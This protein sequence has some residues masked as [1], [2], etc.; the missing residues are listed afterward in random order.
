MALSARTAISRHQRAP[1][2]RA[3]RH[4]SLSHQAV[5]GGLIG[6]LRSSTQAYLRTDVKDE[7][8]TLREQLHEDDQALLILYIDKQLPWREIAIV[9][10]EQTELPDDATLEREAA[11]L[12]KRFERAKVELK[13]LAI[14]KG[15]LER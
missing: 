8:R 9:M 3:D 12:R 1:E 5:L 6:Q 15:L 2:R 14:K 7:F 13:D 4:L 11:R 10:N